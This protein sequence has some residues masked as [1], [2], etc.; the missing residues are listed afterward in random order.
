MLLWKWLSCTGA[1]AAPLGMGNCISKRF[2]II[3]RRL[4]LRVPSCPPS[5][6]GEEGKPDVRRGRA[7]WHRTALQLPGTQHLSG[8]PTV[9]SQGPPPILATAKGTSRC[10]QYDWGFALPPAMS[11][12]RRPKGQVGCSALVSS[13]CSSRLASGMAT[14]F[15]DLDAFFILD[16][17]LKFQISCLCLI[18]QSGKCNPMGRRGVCF[19]VDQ[20]CLL[21][22]VVTSY[23]FQTLT[24]LHGCNRMDV[25]GIATSFKVR[26]CTD[27]ISV[28]LSDCCTCFSTGFPTGQSQ[29]P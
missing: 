15:T 3:S 18:C 12:N 25:C 4:L 22:I 14:F 23:W 11:A 26:N 20:L 5:A 19:P 6:A 1:T 17:G 28:L 2:A 8:Q 16:A 27:F 9:T 24:S 13:L 10:T 7:G 29:L 21:R